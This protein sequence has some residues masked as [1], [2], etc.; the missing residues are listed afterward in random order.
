[1]AA[2]W[3]QK[4]EFCPFFLVVTEVEVACQKEFVK[5]YFDSIN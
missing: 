5:E 3:R 1:M 4:K 2:C